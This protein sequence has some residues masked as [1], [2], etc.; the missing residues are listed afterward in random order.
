MVEMEMEK[1]GGMEEKQ[2][3]EKEEEE[4]GQGRA[5][6]PRRAPGSAAGPHQAQG[7]PCSA[8]APAEHSPLP[9]RCVPSS[10]GVNDGTW[11]ACG[12]AWGPSYSPTGVRAK[13]E[14]LKAPLHLPRGPAAKTEPGWKQSKA[15]FPPQVSKNLAF[16]GK[17]RKR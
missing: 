10:L 1:E 5:P 15:S 17:R 3:E 7:I 8:A 9:A 12:G 16:L 2:K 14:R 11:G 4:E 6:T 13:A